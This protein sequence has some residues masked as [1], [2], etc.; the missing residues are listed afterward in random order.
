MKW[1]EM[2]RH[3]KGRGEEIILPLF[4][5]KV[6]T[7]MPIPAAIIHSSHLQ[8]HCRDIK[9]LHQQLIET[10]QKKKK[11]MIPPL[12]QTK[13]ATLILMMYMVNTKT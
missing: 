2:K 13:S 1:N 11:S 3:E 5:K 12:S 4:E 8:E 7:S 6:P 10:A 9:E